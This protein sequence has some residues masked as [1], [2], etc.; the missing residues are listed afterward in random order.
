[1]DHKMTLARH[2]EQLLAD[3]A[4]KNKSAH[5]GQILFVGSSL[6]EQFPIEEFVKELDLPYAVYNRGIGGYVISQLKA[7]LNT[8]VLDLEPSRIFIN[9]GTNDLTVAE[10]TTESV[11]AHYEALLRQILSALPSARITLMAY[12][13]INIDAAIEQ[14]KPALRIRSNERINE[15]N[16]QVEALAKKLGLRYIDVN[17]ALKDEQGRLKAEYTK[18]GMHI[19]PEGYRAIMPALLP[20]LQEV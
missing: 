10:W 17:D 3:Y 6:M 11:I 18:E 12:Y 20:Y 2:Q 7:A 1:M 13:P 16:R 8:C 9:I 19:K 15:A 5:K 4:E 14:I